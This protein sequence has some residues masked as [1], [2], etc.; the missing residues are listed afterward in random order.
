M[1]TTDYQ[2]VA[3]AVFAA[4]DRQD[5]DELRT[6]PGLYE[7]VQYIPHL[8]AAVPDLRH[9]IQ[10]QFVDGNTVSTVAMARGTHRGALL[11]VPPTGKEISFMVLSIDT[12]VDGKVAVHYGLADWLTILGAVD[13]LPALKASPA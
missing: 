7:T 5:L 3:Q 8:W 4:N 6:H 12:I 9:T 11:G 2:A 13:A 10:R 1:T